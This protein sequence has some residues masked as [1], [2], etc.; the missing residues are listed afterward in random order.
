MKGCTGTYLWGPDELE[1][2]QTIGNHK[3]DEI[4]GDRK[5]S[6][7]ASKEEKQRYVESKYSKL[8]FAG[9]T[10]TAAP[11]RQQAELGKCASQATSEQ[12]IAGPVP[13]AAAAWQTPSNSRRDAPVASKSSIPDSFFED[14]F[15]ETESPKP[16]SSQYPRGCLG[17]DMAMAGSSGFDDLWADAFD[18]Q[19]PPTQHTSTAFPSTLDL[20]A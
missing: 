3:A 9:R 4:Y 5:V 1:K 6:P 12:R 13:V 8:A 14:L 20:L 2:M 19:K 18:M 16:G 7:G 10:K 11:L 15:G 17:C